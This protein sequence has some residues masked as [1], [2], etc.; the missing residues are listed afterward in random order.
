MD[1]C[2]RHPQAGCVSPRRL[3]ADLTACHGESTKHMPTVPLGV[4]AAEVPDQLTQTLSKGCRVQWPASGPNLAHYV[5]C[6][7]I[8]INFKAYVCLPDQRV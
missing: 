8:K 7:D 6:G 2:N 5:P 1:R 3:A 4:F